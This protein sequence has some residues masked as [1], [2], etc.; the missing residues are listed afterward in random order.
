[1]CQILSIGITFT[2]FTKFS[3]NVQVS[4]QLAEQT[5]GRQSPRRSH[6][7]DDVFAAIGVSTLLK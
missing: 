6:K 3:P 1:M 4:R 2:Y 7:T 5:R